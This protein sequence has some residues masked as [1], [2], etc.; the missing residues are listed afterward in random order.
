MAKSNKN[1]NTTK[2]AGSKTKAANKST[3]R[4][5]KDDFVQQN[6]LA[7][8]LLVLGM[9]FLLSITTNALG[10]LG[11][12][13]KAILL[14]QFSTLAVL[15]SLAMLIL[16]MTRLVYSSKFSFHDV[17]P[18]MVMLISTAWMTFYGAVNSK[19]VAEKLSMDL[20]KKVFLESVVRKNIGI[21]P[22][23]LTYWLGKWIGKWGMVLASISIF[24]FVGIYYFRLSFSKLGDAGI[25]L[26]NEGKKVAK[27]IGKRTLDYVTVDEEKAVKKRKAREKLDETKIEDKFGFM[28][29]YKSEVAEF[30]EYIYPNEQ[31]E[32]EPILTAEADE[33]VAEKETAKIF[34]FKRMSD[35]AQEEELR[36][37]EEKYGEAFEESEQEAVHQP[38]EQV[39]DHSIENPYHIEEVSSSTDPKLDLELTK[40]FTGLSELVDQIQPQE[41]SDGKEGIIPQNVSEE[42][43]E[44]IRLEGD[45]VDKRKLHLDDRLK[46]ENIEKLAIPEKNA[47]I[48]PDKKAYTLPPTSL[49]KNYKVQ[50][51][52]Q[53]QQ[54]KDSQKLESTLAIFGIES[55]VVNVSVGPTITR[56]ELQLKIGV[57]VSKILSLSDDLALALAAVAPVRIEAPIPGTS[58]IGIEVPNAQTDIV[59]FRSVLESESFA[60]STGKLP[61][62]LGRDVSGKAII[63]DIAKM[64]H[65]LVAGATGSGKSVC[66]NTLICSILYRANPQDV[67]MIMIDPKMVELSV[68]N[69]IPHLLVPVVTDM[70][71]APYALSWAV[72]EMNNRYKLFAE[73]R[74]RD[75]DGYNEIKGVE[76]LPRIVILVDELA[77]LMMV[78]PNEVED[79]IIRLAQKARACGMHLVIATQRPSVD[80]ITGLI[81]ANIPT[82]I[83]F[84]VSSQVDSRTILDQVGAEKLIGKGDMLFSHPS[85]PKPQRIQGS[86]VSDNEVN[87]VVDFILQQGHTPDTD[88][89]I[90]EE[91]IQR[92]DTNQNEEKDT[93]LDEIIDFA[94][95]NQQISTSLIQRRFRIGY[96]RASRIIDRLEEMGVVSQSDGAKPR[97]VLISSNKDMQ[98]EM[99]DEN[100]NH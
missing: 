71:K 29:R 67:K 61:V 15:L 50:G 81:K 68:Y 99:K 78:S 75:L 13:I 58:L 10:A 23:I 51:N 18:I 31:K 9:V 30:T 92:I 70:K 17:S 63:E 35:D 85:T 2:K 14:G 77:D 3:M 36:A 27:G 38:Q 95:E 33:P 56:F 49:L 86:F 22:Y 88:K 28:E 34:D 45:F 84:A 82:R 26:A 5:A 57:K 48:V 40:K 20:I 65:L 62:A 21:W 24:L 11:K 42:V 43:V 47:Q 89:D 53:S 79:S 93:L 46:K 94:I 64:P 52:K 100:E 76:K 39:S 83:A 90:I 16:G 73:N 66:I 32:E 96:N 74:V 25:A 12:G 7:L 44:E 60:Q 91:T 4:T 8:F 72:N 80:V 55:K 1:K 41:E 6:I 97:K 19:I 59:S 54:L 87:A 37:F 69:N 98:L